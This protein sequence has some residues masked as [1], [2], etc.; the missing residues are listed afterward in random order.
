[1][2]GDQ[3]HGNL[4]SGD[5]RGVRRPGNGSRW[6]PNAAPGAEKFGAA[7]GCGSAEQAGYSHSRMMT[8]K[9]RK[10]KMDQSR[11]EWRSGRAAVRGK[12]VDSR[13]DRA[14]HRRF[15]GSERWHDGVGACEPEHGMVASSSAGRD[16]NSGTGRRF[17]DKCW[18]DSGAHT[19]G[20]IQRK[21]SACVSRGD[22][23]TTTAHVKV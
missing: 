18:P 16:H 1:L 22:W 13:S 11:G 21:R 17:A 7:A 15:A 23:T 10:W 14:V 20:A 12:P 2:R 6:A 9:R 5:N 8:G 4:V 19:T 3:A